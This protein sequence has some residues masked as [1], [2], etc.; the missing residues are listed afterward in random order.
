MQ[1]KPKIWAEQRG[2]KPEELWVTIVDFPEG[3]DRPH[4]ALAFLTRSPMPQLPAFAV[5]KNSGDTTLVKSA[6][7]RLPLIVTEDR[8]EKL[9]CFTFRVFADVFS[10]I[11]EEEPLKLSYWM[12]PVK[13]N[14]SVNEDSLEAER[15]IS[16]IA[17]ID[18]ALLD[19][20]LANVEYRWNPD[21]PHHF[22]INKFIVDKFDGGRKFF[23][24]GVEPSLKQ[25]D[26]VPDDANK[27]KN[28]KSIIDYSVSLWKKSRSKITWADNQPVIETRL[29]VLRRNMLA[30]PEKKEVEGI[31]KAYVCP[32]ILK[33]SALTPEIATACIV[34]PSVIHRLESYLISIEGC[35][36]IGLD[37]GP[38]F[39]LAAFTK[40][41]DN[42]GEHDAERVNFQRGMGENYERLEFIGD[43]FLK[44]ATTIST[45][46]QNPNENEFEFHVRRMQML[47]NKNLF[48]TALK[49][50]LYEYVRSMAFNRR[51]W[52]PEGLK[53][54]KGTGVIQGQA[55]ENFHEPRNHDLGEKTI[56]DVCEALIGAAYL[57]WDQPGSWQPEHWTNAVKAVTTL[58]DS[59]DH[60]MLTW[61]DYRKAYRK[62]HYQIADVT[63][64]QRDLAQK[65][66]REHAYH[67]KYP[68]LL[69]S[70][71]MHPSVPYIY[72]KV[73]NY[74][75]LEFLGD[76]LLDQASITYLFHKYPD[77][78][79]QW[80]TEHKMAMVSNKFLGALCVNIGFHKHLRHH[81]AAM[82][83]QITTYAADLLEAKRVAGD[84]RDYW[85][86][87]ADPPKCLPDIIEA[88]VGAM[89]IDSDFS[90]AEVQR[91]FDEHVQWFFEDM[92]VYDTFANNHPCTHLHNMLQTTFGC[93]DYRLMA[94]ELP[95]IDGVE[96]KD[97]VAVVMIHDRIVAH[98]AGKSGRYA[99]L[100]VA[101]KALEKLDGLAPFDFRAK[102]G[103]CCKVDED[104]QVKLGQDLEGEALGGLEGACGV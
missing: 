83:S 70:S 54:L 97:V 104:G 69:F 4:Q 1:I 58:V 7:L 12:A 6:S 28:A 82:Q 14:L 18:W 94:K 40:D 92:T 81:H 88:F 44:T 68:R 41:S 3:L 76:A 98:S 39:A 10:K 45:F 84:S 46:I 71:F 22:Y 2:S 99:R 38:R 102:Y 65:V 47:C 30:P 75:R 20:V 29:A 93:M 73:P 11:Y 31:T 16:P 80:L 63:A 15:D 56:A 64:V 103:C 5:Y 60:R 101:N 77:K 13:L 62:P 79:P 25:T 48:G 66:E 100:R 36:T 53:L 59:D 55:K 52:Y 89:F 87:V 78:D 50:K 37:C 8:L 24:V 86:T 35:T 61:D 57:T 17:A 96:R 51:Y 43:T 91:F 67:F 72:E 42:Q 34:W 19:E 90:Y 26:P 49:L 27:G 9:S 23:S 95:S 32:E 74:Q 33:I 85:T 21:T